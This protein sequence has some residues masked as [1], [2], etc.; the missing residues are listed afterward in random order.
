M[1]INRI[2]SHKRPAYTISEDAVFLCE[3][4]RTVTPLNKR[5]SFKNSSIRNSFM[6]LPARS[7]ESIRTRFRKYY[8]H[9]DYKEMRIVI[10]MAKYFPLLLASIELTKTS[11]GDDLF[12]L[13]GFTRM[14]SIASNTYNADIFMTFDECLDYLYAIENKRDSTGVINTFNKLYTLPDKEYY[15]YRVKTLRNIRVSRKKLKTSLVD[16]SYNEESDISKSKA[17]KKFASKSARNLEKESSNSD[18]EVYNQ[19]KNDGS[20]SRIHEEFSQSSTV[21]QDWDEFILESKELS[22]SIQ[23]NI[24]KSCSDSI[25]YSL[26]SSSPSKKKPNNEKSTVNTKIQAI[27]RNK[28]TQIKDSK[29]LVPRIISSGLNEEICIED[30]DKRLLVAIPITGA[31]EKMQKSIDI[32]KLLN[33]EFAKD[34][35]IKYFVPL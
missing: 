2:A 24:I 25:S 27:S 17:N 12:K 9:M 33:Q 30:H 29:H 31:F 15:R 26:P 1:D 6:K 32:M 28:R 3:H 22:M 11:I 10:E 21:N 20:D 13:N 18:S 16:K 5:P 14:I 8:K 23:E 4:L 7:K 34:F 19:D 35:N